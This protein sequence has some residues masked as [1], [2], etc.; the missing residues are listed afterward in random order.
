MAQRYFELKSEINNLKVKNAELEAT[1]QALVDKVSDLGFEVALQ[2]DVCDVEEEEKLEAEIT[3]LRQVV[4]DKN[5]EKPVPKSLVVAVFFRQID[6][7]NCYWE[8]YT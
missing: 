8:R 7:G 1:I 5:L 2:R 3:R 6:T 4:A